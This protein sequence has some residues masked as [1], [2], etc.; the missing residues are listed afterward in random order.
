MAHP[1]RT[2][3]HAPPGDRLDDL[4]ADAAITIRKTW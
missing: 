2:V 3:V 1:E 4:K